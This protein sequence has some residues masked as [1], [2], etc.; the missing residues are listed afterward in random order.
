MSLN[1]FSYFLGFF[2]L[3]I[4][5]FVLL[6]WIQIRFRTLIPFRQPTLMRCGWTL[7]KAVHQ[8]ETSQSLTGFELFC[9]VFLG[10][11]DSLT[12]RHH[13]TRSVI[14]NT[15]KEVLNKS[16][17]TPL[18]LSPLNAS[19]CAYFSLPEHCCE[20]QIYICTWL[21]CQTDVRFINNIQ[22]PFNRVDCHKQ[23]HLRKNTHKSNQFIT[24]L[25]GVGTV[26][27]ASDKILST[28][29][30]WAVDNPWSKHK[31]TVVFLVT[32]TDDTKQYNRLLV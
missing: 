12:D 18:I 4:W 9:L 30:L 19:I 15:S 25:G 21:Y 29:D 7:R 1:L 31:Q 8:K 23:V 14:I 27:Q 24:Q 5:F 6:N 2:N 28:H 10:H 22:A 32:H 20:H 3:Q 13:L 26:E 17:F 11:F 16:V